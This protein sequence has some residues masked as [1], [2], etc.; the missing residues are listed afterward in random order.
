MIT[1]VKHHDLVDGEIKKVYVLMHPYD[2]EACGVYTDKS[3]AE[4]YNKE[5]GW[6]IEEYEI[7]APP[8]ALVRKEE[9]RERACA[10][11]DA[12]SYVPPTYEEIAKQI[13]NLMSQFFNHYNAERDVK[14]R[15]YVRQVTALLDE[16]KTLGYDYQALE[17][18]IDERLRQNV[19]DQEKIKQAEA[20][21]E[22]E[23]AKRKQGEAERLKGL[24]GPKCIIEIDQWEREEPEGSSNYEVVWHWAIGEYLSYDCACTNC[25]NIAHGDEHARFSE[26]LRAALKYFDES[27]GADAPFEFR[28]NKHM[29]IECS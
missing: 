10:A 25:E 27:Y 3:L 6:L 5:D 8:P 14:A 28:I 9:V 21:R 22:K 13:D 1:K 16:A 29:E 2:L 11:A 20:E 26:A 19:Q 23:V 12:A 7:N 18:T 4:A 24:D 17:K 15:R